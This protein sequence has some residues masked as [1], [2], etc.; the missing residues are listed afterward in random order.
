MDYWV[1]AYY[2]FTPIE[3]PAQEV[4]RHKDFFARRDIR[5]RIYISSE[6]I[7]GQISAQPAEAQSYMEWLKSDSR[8][9][10]VEFKIH[11]WTEHCFPRATIKMRPQLVALDT[12]ADPSKA[13]HRLSSEEWKKRLDVHDPN[14]VLIDVR[15]RYEWELG[16]FEGAELPNLEQFRDF[17]SYAEDLK[18]RH[19]PKTTK[20]MMYCT[21]GIRCELYSALLKEEGFEE[22]YQLKGGI[23]QY[24]LEQGS[25]H[26]RGKLFVFDDRLSV[27]I[28]EKEA[29]DIISHCKY[30]QTLTD[31]YFNCA[32]MDCNELFL[33]CNAC[34]EKACGCCSPSCEKAPRVRPFQKQDRPKPFRRLGPLVHGTPS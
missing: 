24:G 11:T 1:L 26:W 13:G 23:I 17:P 8:F 29:S 30:C 18:K 21:G 34:A 15:N 10:E 25:K 19:D 27:P 22:V 4:F 32:N 2:F 16:H 3:D 31:L 14:R 28:S 12:K 33:A 5:G 20:V 7:N 9:Q 6:G